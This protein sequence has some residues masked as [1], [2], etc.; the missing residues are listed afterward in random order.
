MGVKLVC[1]NTNYEL[2]STSD[3]KVQIIKEFKG[4]DLEDLCDSAIATMH[5][6]YGFSMGFNVNLTSDYTTILENYFRGVL[7]VPERILIVARMDNVIAGSIQL[8]K[9]FPNNYTTS[10]AGSIESHFVAPWAR[11]HGLAKHLLDKAEELA[12]DFNLSI[13]KLSVNVTHEAAIKLYENSGYQKWGT[14]EKHELIGNTLVAG[15]YYYKNL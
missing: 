2:S 4:S 14:L 11:G 12:H 10:F 15:N 13:I 3:I 6:S 8:L 9:P 7:L 5:D 1:K